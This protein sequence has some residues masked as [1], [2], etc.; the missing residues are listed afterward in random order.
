M[1]ITPILFWLTYV[2]GTLA[3]LIYP[4]V[5][6]MLYI[7]VYHM[8]PETQW[9]GGS[10]KA[11]GLRTSLAVAIATGVGVLVRPPRFAF[12]ARQFPLPYVLALLLT[13]LAVASLNWG[14][15][16]TA[17]GEY[18]AEKMIKLMIILFI[19]IRCVQTPLHYQLVFLSWIGGVFYLGYEATGGTGSNVAG[20]LTQGIGGPD[21]SE[22]SGL[23]VHLVASLPLI[24]AGFFMARSV[25][26]RALM[27]ITGALVVNTLIMTRTRNA[28][29]GLAAM[30]LATV[31][32]LPPRYRLKG[33]AAAVVGTLLSVQLVDPA[34]WQRMASV[35]DYKQDP[36][37]VQ[38]LALWRAAF[39]MVEDYPFGVGFGNFHQVVKEYVP[40]LTLI[41]SAHN[42][43]LACMAELGW[44]GLFLFLLLLLVTFWR[45]G[46]GRRVAVNLPAFERLRVYRWE[47][48]F[49]LGWHATALRAALVGYLTCAM[50]TTRL[51]SEDLWLLIGLAACL[52]NVTRRMQGRAATAA[53]EQA[54]D[55]APTVLPPPVTEALPGGLA[56][57][58]ASPSLIP[59]TAP[60]AGAPRLAA[61]AS[62][63]PTAKETVLR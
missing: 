47:L 18:N 33:I 54:A 38:R 13:L 12:G 23:A 3:A 40:G 24:G 50:F 30:A 4:V 32:A 34:W 45:L 55:D 44:P 7:L 61:G 6:M 37:A 10:V 15:R 52:E 49:H 43:V 59:A 58:P 29:F 53:A 35:W 63:R 26:G 39:K 21:F 8:N 60:P 1:G 56:A 25:W 28:L 57:G 17:R 5:G 62:D 14:V 16:I 36:A 51:A 9:W 41:R 20:R 11:S 2:G 42:T 22:S 46:H 27:L 31:L 48:R 19:L